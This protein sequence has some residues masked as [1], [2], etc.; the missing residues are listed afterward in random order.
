M[1][2]KG[3]AIDV[4]AK[5]EETFIGTGWLKKQMVSMFQK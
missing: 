5:W 2:A 3:V 4:L 1:W